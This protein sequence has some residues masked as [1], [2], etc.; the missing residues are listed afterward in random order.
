[1]PSPSPKA[2]FLL[3]L[4]ACGAGGSAGPDLDLSR[5]APIEFTLQIGG[6]RQVGAAQITFEGVSGDSRCP[7]DVQCVWAGD[8]AVA[9]EV[10]P[11]AGDG[12]A[13]QITLHTGVE[14]RAAEVLGLRITLLE[15][16]PTP[17]AG[18]PI[19]PEEYRATLRVV[20]TRYG[21]G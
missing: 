11:A 19:G 3:L 5:T 1:M 8:A 4:A 12:P 20:G 13:Y 9:L 18:V 2:G 16:A 17:V 10:G 21:G 14:P 15:L 7:A 6:Q